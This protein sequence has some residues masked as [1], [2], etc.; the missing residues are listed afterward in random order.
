MQNRELIGEYLSKTVMSGPLRIESER[1]LMQMEKEGQFG[2]NLLQIVQTNDDKCSYA[3]LI[4][5]KN[6]VKKHWAEDVI[7][8][9]LNSILGPLLF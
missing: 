5:F 4:Y 8:Y 9:K 2:I 6:F 3:A 1:K 7:N